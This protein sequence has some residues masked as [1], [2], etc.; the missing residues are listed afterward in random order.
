MLI[1]T[2][3]YNFTIPSAC[4]FYLKDLLINR[5]LP[6]NQTEYITK[7]AMAHQCNS[8]VIITAFLQVYNYLFPKA[9]TL[10][11][12]QM[13]KVKRF[14]PSQLKAKK[15]RKKEKITII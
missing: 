6:H 2:P 15:I 10:T 3:E 13:E 7:L 14:L 4:S 8:T 5:S 12:E 1:Y 9:E 11:T